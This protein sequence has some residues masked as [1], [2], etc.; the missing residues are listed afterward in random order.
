[1][2]EAI[3]LHYSRTIKEKKNKYVLHFLKIIH[4]Q[5]RRFLTPTSD[6]SRHDLV[7]SLLIS[8]W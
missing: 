5:F 6:E 1:M 8:Y 2:R 3:M 7:T 4:Q